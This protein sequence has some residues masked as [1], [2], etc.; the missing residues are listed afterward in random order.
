MLRVQVQH[1]VK[2]LVDERFEDGVWDAAPSGGGVV[3]DELLHTW[4]S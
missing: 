2:Q 1:A 4:H 3:V